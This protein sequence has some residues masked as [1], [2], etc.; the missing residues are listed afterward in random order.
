M[1]NKAKLILFSVL[2]ALIVIVGIVMVA[3]F[4]GFRNA[5]DGNRI[6][7]NYDTV[8]TIAG[9][10]E[11]LEKTCESVLSSRGLKQKNKIN[12]ENLD[13]ASIGE[14]GD[15]TI[16]YLFSSSTDINTLRQAVTQI[17]DRVA[18]EYPEADIYVSVHT[19]QSMMLIEPAWRGAIALAVAAVAAV[20][21]LAIRFGFASAVAGCI[22]SLVAGLLS[23]AIY[24]IIPLPV[25]SYAPLLYAGIGT[26][27]AL[28]VW[29]LEASKLRK[30]FK[31]TNGEILSAEEAVKRG[32]KGARKYALLFMIPIA[33][34]FVLLGALATNAT[35]MF[36]LPALLP[37]AFSMLSAMLYA[38]CIMIPIKEK[39]DSKKV[40][41]RYVGKQ[42]ADAEQ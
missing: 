26:V 41:K 7:V 14:T 15:H 18:S 1:T 21:Y 25:Y 6:E 8:I 17:K 27:F 35:R 16:I 23:A 32:L 29:M 31:E 38:P 39:T 10:E 13:S 3:V 42:K 33:A 12:S 28:F 9:K 5:S 20:I 36:F 37:I 30:S 11:A 19:S 4:G 2:S 34:A 22:S 40:Q 24:A